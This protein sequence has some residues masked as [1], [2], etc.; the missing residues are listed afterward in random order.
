MHTRVIIVEQ[1][2]AKPSEKGLYGST[3]FEDGITRIFINSS[4]SKKELLDTLFHE[5]A[6]AVMRWH[7]PRLSKVNE[8]RLARLV[9]NVV[10]PCFK[11]FRR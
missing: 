11:R 8:E 3:T 7:G 1:R 9:G 10:E 6:H 5:F 2:K 4:Q